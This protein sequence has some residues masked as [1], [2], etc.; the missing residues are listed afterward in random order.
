MAIRN[1]RSQS[2]SFWTQWTLAHKK[3]RSH[4]I[5]HIPSSSLTR[6]PMEHFPPASC[7]IKKPFGGCPAYGQ[8]LWHS[9]AC[10]WWRGVYTFILRWINKLRQCII[11]IKAWV[12]ELSHQTSCIQNRFSLYQFF[13]QFL[14]V[15]ILLCFSR[16]IQSCLW[17]GF[18][19]FGL[20]WLLA[21]GPSKQGSL[22]KQ[23][24]R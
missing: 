13:T 20:F 10:T 6:F 21:F 22:T 2:M 18:F 12:E 5:S 14:V 11:G 23:A 24:I 15:V 3:G 8:N 4:H 16:R 9:I 7:S 19:F 1:Q 17:F